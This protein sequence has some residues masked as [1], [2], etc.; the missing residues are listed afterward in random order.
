MLALAPST[1]SAGAICRF[2]NITVSGGGISGSNFQVTVIG[3]GDTA[4]L[5]QCA[6]IGAVYIRVTSAST[7]SNVTFNFG[8]SP[9]EHTATGGGGAVPEPTSFALAAVGFVALG[10][11]RL[12]RW[13]RGRAGAVA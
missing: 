1:A 10:T 11:T 5:S 7:I 4:L 13:R 9:N 2:N 8:T 6:F 3:S 12:L